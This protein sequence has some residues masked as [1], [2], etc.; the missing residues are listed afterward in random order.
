[1]KVYKLENG[2]SLH[3][4]KVIYD[5]QEFNYVKLLGAYITSVSDGLYIL[6]DGQDVI[7]KKFIEYL[8]SPENKLKSKNVFQK[9]ILGVIINN[10]PQMI[11][12]G[13][14]LFDLVK[15]VDDISNVKL[16]IHISTT[17][18]F[19]LQDYSKSSIEILPTNNT[20]TLVVDS[21]FKGKDILSNRYKISE[22]LKKDVVGE[23]LSNLRDDR[24]NQLFLSKQIESENT[25]VVEDLLKVFESYQGDKLSYENMLEESFNLM[26]KYTNI[27]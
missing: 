1:M 6:G 18:R 26:N 21:Y 2:D 9:Y 24:L 15:D 12:V 20:S 13:K 5:N 23:I 19:N 8:N 7:L 14:T 27:S 16:N 17:M 10:E 4:C 22:I 3:L 25:K 11:L